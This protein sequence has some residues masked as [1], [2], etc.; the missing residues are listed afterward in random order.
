MGNPIRIK[1]S[2]GLLLL[3]MLTALAAGCSFQPSDEERILA[4]LYLEA[5]IYR[6]RNIA[7]ADSIWDRE[8]TVFDGN[9]T[10][11]PDDDYPLKSGLGEIQG[12]YREMLS[13][14]EYLQYLVNV[15]NLIIYRGSASCTTSVLV[16]ARDTYSGERSVYFASKIPWQFTFRDG[17]WKIKKVTIYTE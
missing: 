3:V 13:G 12:Y 16:T 10:G 17:F 15:E 6:E 9:F 2:A 8:G 4:L 5:D 7:I 14:I 1:R 11:N